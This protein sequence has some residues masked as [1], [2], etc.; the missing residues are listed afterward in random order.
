MPS[1]SNKKQ[2]SKH[3]SSEDDSDED[4]D[5]STSGRLRR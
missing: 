2:P 3:N 4:I 1:N 5:E